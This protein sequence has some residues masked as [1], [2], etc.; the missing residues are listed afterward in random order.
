LDVCIFPQWVTVQTTNSDCLLTWDK[1]ARSAQ[2]SRWN[3]KN[4]FFAL[5]C[6]LNKHLGIAEERRVRWYC[7]IALKLQQNDNPVQLVNASRSALEFAKGFCGALIAKHAS[8]CFWHVC[9]SSRV[10]TDRDVWQP[11]SDYRNACWGCRLTRGRNTW[12]KSFEFEHIALNGIL[13][14]TPSICLHVW[15]DFSCIQSDFFKKQMQ[16]CQ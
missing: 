13:R 12:L 15:C 5:L 11:Q 9:D 14:K 2:H 4:A 3:K 7:M 1:D 8:T 10:C 16:T 6:T